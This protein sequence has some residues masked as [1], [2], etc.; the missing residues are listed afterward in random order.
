M[1]HIKNHMRADNSLGDS[2]GSHSCGTLL[3]RWYHLISKTLYLSA[4]EFQRDLWRKSILEAVDVRRAIVKEKRDRFARGKKKR[5][6]HSSKCC[7][8]LM[9]DGFWWLLVWFGWLID[10][11]TSFGVDVEMDHLDWSNGDSWSFHLPCS[12]NQLVHLGMTYFQQNG[13]GQMKCGGFM[14]CK[15]YCRR[16]IHLTTGVS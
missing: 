2:L 12:K 8:H 15:D 4:G 14:F 6:V 13:G 7:N 16:Y 11:T 9:V 3:K 10:W 5:A 1:E